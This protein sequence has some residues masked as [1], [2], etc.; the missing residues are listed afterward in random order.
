MVKVLDKQEVCSDER[1]VMTVRVV[2][3]TYGPKVNGL[4]W[5]HWSIYLLLQD[6]RSSVRSNMR[7]KFDHYNNGLLEWSDCGYVESNSDIAHWDYP[8][9]PGTKVQDVAKLIYEKGR[10]RYDLVGGKGCRFWM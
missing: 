9:K 5:N 4:S 2:V 7:A 8:C 10:E 3:H 1:V 6:G